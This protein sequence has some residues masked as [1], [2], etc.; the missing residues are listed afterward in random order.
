MYN[1]RRDSFSIK[2]VLLQILFVIV[3]VFILMW[4]FPTKKQVENL[5]NVPTYDNVFNENI[6]AMKEAAKSYYTTPRLP[7]NVGDK[8]S[9]TLGEMLDLKIILPF[10]DSKGRACSETESYVEVT[11]KEEEY[12]MKINLKCPEEENYLLVYMGCYDYCKTTICEKNDKDVKTPVINP[13]NPTPVKPTP[14]PK[15][16]KKCEITSCPSGHTLVNKNSADCYCKKDEVPVAKEYICEYLKVSDASYGPWGSWSEYTE[17]PVYKTATQDVRTKEKTVTTTQKV[18]VGYKTTT[19]YDETKPIYEKVNVKIGTKTT[20]SCAKYTTSYV[21]T[22]EYEYGAW[23]ANGTQTFSNKDVPADTATKK[24]VFANT[25]YNANCGLCANGIEYV[26]TVYTRSQIPVKKEQ[27]TC[28]QWTTKTEDV[29]VAKD[30]L[31]G[32]ETS[33]KKE[34]VY[35]TRSVDTKV[36]LYSYR[37]R[38]LN[39]GTPIYKWDTCTN[40]P[41]LSQDYKFTGKKEEK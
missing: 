22:G 11:K 5:I 13:T 16:V 34:E 18:L 27:Y 32:Y 7:K 21:N 23:T 14:T 35:E 28:T 2:E 19:Y 39:E 20:K 6:L 24:Y 29:Y 12:I 36:T 40:S 31:K 9:M 41:L 8:V 26:Y 4:I 38:T 17:T 3:F 15:P 30:V 1:E 37:T 25:Q 33:T 10:T